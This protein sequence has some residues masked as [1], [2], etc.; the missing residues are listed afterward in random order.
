MPPALVSWTHTVPESSTSILDRHRSLL[1]SRQL[2]RVSLGNAAIAKVER[3]VASRPSEVYPARRLDGESGGCVNRIN[4]VGSMSRAADSLHD[5]RPFHDAQARFDVA[6]SWNMAQGFADLLGDSQAALKG[7]ART[8]RLIEEQ[9]L[10]DGWPVGRLYGGESELAQRYGVGQAMVRETVRILEARGTA[11]M[12]PGRNASLEVAVP[13][14]EE[15]ASGIGS[16]CYLIGV[17]CAQV[18]VARLIVDRAAARLAAERAASGVIPSAVLTEAETT[19]EH[20]WRRWLIDAAGN[21]AIA[22]YMRC[23]DGASAA[24][25]PDGDH[26]LR[27]T[28]SDHWSQC[29]ERL[30]KAVA[31][32]D[33][34][35]A[36]A[37]ADTCSRRSSTRLQ[38]LFESQ[39]AVAQR[40][41]PRCTKRA[42]QIVTDLLHSLGPGQWRDGVF[43]GNE[44]GLC[45]RYGV[46]R[47]A[48][49]QAIRIL[50]A[51]EAAVTV[52][53]RG[54][55]LMACSP[56]PGALSRLMCCH[57]A[58]TKMAHHHMLRAFE[59][60]SIE[61]MAHT[62]LHAD[63]TRVARMTEEA[64]VVRR[65]KETF[66]PRQQAELEAQHF[67]LADNPLLELFLRS[68][69]AFASWGPV[70]MSQL[71]GVRGDLAD[72]A[73][74]LT[75]ALVARD[76]VAAAR[77][78]ARKFAIVKSSLEGNGAT[79]PGRSALRHDS[80][81]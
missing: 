36:V 31:R 35:A 28:A 29:G 21:P 17:S 56:K 80:V 53:G 50:E 63:A 71:S 32:G 81:A 9:F 70:G 40:H 34:H 6:L 52:P 72:C 25:L 7:A 57:F 77:A 38:M 54:H 11:R 8:A 39:P 3:G 60:L 19:D 44:E 13:P 69:R 49:R 2:I 1:R 45:A 73:G 79:A 37:W 20:D 74:E 61:T 76:P 67:A 18:A 26:S 24:Q 33:A 59:W 42:L 41:S 55:G 48:M 4:D 23:L 66:S 16:Y 12:R 68:A 14:Q 51:G 22:F 30:R 10:T 46:D 15:L 75:D 64:T 62:A 43:L 78:Q 47:R 5:I 65:N 58:A 27:A